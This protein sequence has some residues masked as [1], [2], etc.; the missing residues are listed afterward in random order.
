MVS[1]GNNDS[2]WNT[3]SYD[4]A[5][6]A[7]D[8]ETLEE[9]CQEI[10]SLYSDIE[11]DCTYIRE[12]WEDHYAT[13]FESL[14]PKC[15]DILMDDVKACVF[16]LQ[17]YY[18]ACMIL[19]GVSNP[20]TGD[21]AQDYFGRL[22]DLALE[23]EVAAAV[24]TS[25]TTSSG[26]K[27]CEYYVDIL[28]SELSVPRRLPPMCQCVVVSPWDCPPYPKVSM[29]EPMAVV[30]EVLEVVG[31]DGT[32]SVNLGVRDAFEYCVLVEELSVEDRV[33]VGDKVIV[34]AKYW[35]GDGTMLH[36]AYYDGLAES[37]CRV[38][39]IAEV[40]ALRYDF[41]VESVQLAHDF[42]HYQNWLN[43]N[44]VVRSPSELHEAA[45]RGPKNREIAE[46]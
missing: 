27:S 46:S 39:T 13:K 15:L 18:D 2:S 4:A 24:A 41:D 11:V 32:T 44:W 8:G 25:Y 1:Y 10:E 9:L 14:T 3:R 26:D 45:R 19:G 38:S 34:R 5:C 33:G 12:H 42:K 37:V 29:P 17:R 22:G 43:A 36:G 20:Q 21:T 23:L 40:M 16:N 31:C 7:Y 35:L 30:L 28:C 6:D